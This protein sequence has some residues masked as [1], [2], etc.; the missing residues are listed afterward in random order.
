MKSSVKNNTLRR[1]LTQWQLYALILPAVIYLFLFNYMPMYGVQIAF[2]DFRVGRGIWASEWVGL[3]HFIAFINFPGFYNIM[4]NTVR[5]SLY[6]FATFPLSIILA[7][8]LNEVENQPFKKTVQMITYAPYFISVVVICSMITLFLNRSGGIVNNFVEL[9][10]GERIPFLEIP[11]YF[12]SIFVWSDVWQGIGWGTIIYLAALSSVSPELIEAARIDGATRFKIIRHVNIPAII[13]TIV[14]ILILRCGSILSVGFDKAFLLQNPL[15]LEASQVI[16]TYVYEIGLL[17]SRHSY[18]SAIGLFN[19]VI[20]I[21][22]M[23]IVNGVSKR[24][25]DVSLW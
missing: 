17:N 13:P 12:A 5:I 10:G 25:A 9:F 20:N 1:M 21:T 23:L 8:M 7:L 6:S 2:K 19:T 22:F 16:S 15:N 3:K 24:V 18:S 4:R 14:I 11:S